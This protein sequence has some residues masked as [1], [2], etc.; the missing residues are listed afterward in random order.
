MKIGPVK[1]PIIFRNSQPLRPTAGQP[2]LV[3]RV[4]QE[5]GTIKDVHMTEEEYKE[6]KKQEDKKK[7]E[8]LQ[9][10]KIKQQQVWL[11]LIKRPGA[12]TQSERVEN[13]NNRNNKNTGFQ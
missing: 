6:Y 4:E 9:Q 13:D 7:E 3:V 2:P 5:D 11:E 12:Y 8:R 10:E 1:S